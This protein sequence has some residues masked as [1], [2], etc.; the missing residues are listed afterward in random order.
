MS[1]IQHM[2]QLAMLQEQL[3][4]NIE[5]ILMGYKYNLHPEPHLNADVEHPPYG[6]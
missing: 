6:T 1:T 3:L 5:D 2:H 4:G